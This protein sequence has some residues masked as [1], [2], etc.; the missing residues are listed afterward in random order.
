VDDG[1][2]S[3]LGALILLGIICVG[4]FAAWVVLG[5]GDAWI[6]AGLLKLREMADFAGDWYQ[7]TVDGPSRLIAPA[8][9][10]ASGSYAI[11][12]AYKY[13]ERRLHYRLTDY[14][15]REERRLADAR[16]QLRLIVERPNVDRWF[17][18]PVFLVPPLKR[19]VRELG[20][21]SYFLGPQ[22]G[23]VSFQL[24]ASVEQLTRQIAISGL[25]HQH[26]RKQLATA[27]VLKGAMHVAEASASEGDPSTTRVRMI[28]ALNHFDSALSVDADDCDALEY[29]GHAHV[30]LRDNVQANARLDRVLALTEGVG[31]SLSRARA[32]RYKADL[33]AANGN[34]GI[35][36]RRLYESLRALPNLPDDDRI[37]EAE[38]H[39]NL[40]DRHMNLGEHVRARSHWEIALALFQGVK[41]K[42][43]LEG[44]A[45]VRAKLAQ[46]DQRPDK[47]DDSD[48]D[49]NNNGG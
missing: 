45:R 26:L 47:D 48:D 12:K 4:I 9:S 37:E 22:L 35:A 42:A 21:G 13:A 36:K 28:N 17:R 10:I 11:F 25:R 15:E 16:K 18:K 8:I 44:V 39:E 2:T 5:P 46:L 33:A 19:A 24:D 30:A 20:W 34:N 43:G 38:I 6:A 14:L 27:H 40:G 32:L 31:R 41:T 1:N 49:D 29:A 23:Y 7:K 3:I